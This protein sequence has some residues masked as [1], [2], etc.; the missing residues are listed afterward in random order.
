M[1]REAEYNAPAHTGSVHE[2]EAPLS[3]SRGFTD[4]PNY[5]RENP[6]FDEEQQQQQQQAQ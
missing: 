2:Q 3:G 6:L 5:P 1:N 4:I